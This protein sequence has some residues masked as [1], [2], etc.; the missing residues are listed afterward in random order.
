[1]TEAEIRKQTDEAERATLGCMLIEKQAVSAALQILDAQ[2]FG[3][4]HHGAIFDAC[5]RLHEGGQP[6]DTISVANELRAAPVFDERGFDTGRTWYEQIGGDAVGRSLLLNLMDA[7]TSAANIAYYAELVQAASLRRFGLAQLETL[8]SLL[9][10]DPDGLKK[11]QDSNGAFHFS[12]ILASA[13]KQAEWEEPIPL[14]QRRVADFPAAAL[15]DWLRQWAEADSRAKE[16]PL[17]LQGLLALG[18]VSAAITGKVQVQVKADWIEPVNIYAAPILPSG[19]RKSP[20]FQSAIA[21]IRRWEQERVAQ[22][23]TCIAEAESQRRILEAKRKKAEGEA[24]THKDPLKRDEAEHDAGRYAAELA[25]FTM[26]PSGKLLVD[27]VTPEEFIRRLHLY[28]GRIAVLSDEAG[29]FATFSGRYN[30][31]KTNFDAFCKAYDG[32]PIRNERAGRKEDESF[33]IPRPL[34]TVVL[35]PQPFIMQQTS[36][37][38][39]LLD[40]GVLARFLFALPQPKAGYR[41]NR[42][43]PAPQLVLDAYDVNLTRLLNLTGAQTEDGKPTLITLR[44]SNEAAPLF[45]AFRDEVE[46]MLRPGGEL[47]DAKEWGNKLAGKTAR[48]AGLL[49]MAQWAAD[50]AG[51]NPNITAETTAAAIAMGRYAVSHAL[52]AFGQIGVNPTLK[53]AKKILDWIL[54]KQKNE[55]SRRELQTE[56][57]TLFKEVEA[58][59]KP[60][61]LLEEHHY[62]RGVKIHSEKGGRPAGPR[63]EVN[64]KFTISGKSSANSAKPAEKVGFAEFAEQFPEEKNNPRQSYPP[65]APPKAADEDPFFDEIAPVATAEPF[66]A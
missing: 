9:Q 54:I 42:T 6:V 8:R 18:A 61:R 3:S 66:A 48:I 28:G 56:K 31:G 38:P 34:A 47:E 14:P 64:P 13:R 25:A 44:L 36:D 24:V 45:L 7:P 39:A 49:H 20:P 35:T 5:R 53:A 63:Y 26:P 19:E 51:W 57:P 33:D 50:V 23:K 52:A 60:L 65:D 21:P 11:V 59:D 12:E 27:D 29:L 30:D 46:A 40:Q 17:D 15:P 58:C 22:Q 37:T 10:F 16:T 41:T 43:A 32:S 2:H 55:F 1:M 62:I 4:L